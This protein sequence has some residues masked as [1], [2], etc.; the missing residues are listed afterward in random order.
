LRTKYFAL[1]SKMNDKTDELTDA[2]SRMT[3]KSKNIGRTINEPR[4]ASAM[5]Y[6]GLHALAAVPVLAAPGGTGV[7]VLMAAAVIVIVTSM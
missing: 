5:L 6:C 7:F 1:Q 4:A 2:D 3:T